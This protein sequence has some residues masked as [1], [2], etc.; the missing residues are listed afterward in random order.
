MQGLSAAT[1]LGVSGSLWR[2]LDI[3]CA[4]TLLSRTLG[5]AVGAHTSVVTTICNQ[6]FPCLLMAWAFL[7]KRGEGWPPLTLG[8]ASQTL[9]LV[10]IAGL[11]AKAAFEGAATL[12]SYSKSRGTKAALFFFLGFV[13]FPLPELAPSF[14]W[15]AHS[16]W[17]LFL[18]AGY[19]LLYEEL[20]DQGAALEAKQ[21]A[22]MVKREQKMSKN[23]YR[24]SS[25][26]FSRLLLFP[27]SA[28]RRAKAA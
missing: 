17:H 3:L 9:F 26:G 15:L 23:K 1:V 6:L 8:S 20:L 21:R 28:A 19:S 10:M 4:Q 13:C 5:H 16:L 24:S 22:A 12:P 27:S 14:Y 25:P 7:S 11:A 2:S 18:A